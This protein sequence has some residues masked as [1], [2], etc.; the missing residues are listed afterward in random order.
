MDN[1]METAPPQHL[2]LLF[3]PEAAVNDLVSSRFV[4]LVR[5]SLSGF[6]PQ[7]CFD[8]DHTG[9]HIFLDVINIFAWM[10]FFLDH[11]VSF[12]FSIASPFLFYHRFIYDYERTCRSVWKAQEHNDTDLTNDARVARGKSV[13]LR[14]SGRAA[15]RS[16]L[17]CV[18][19]LCYVCARR[20]QRGWRQEKEG[21]RERKRRNKGPKNKVR[22]EARQDRWLY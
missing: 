22:R 10:C 7:W 4:A 9:C 20:G 6:E 12:S 17:S 11:Y 15:T 3:H 1:I 14:H 19:V 5:V 18:C 2:F 13:T 8:F 16:S 21:E